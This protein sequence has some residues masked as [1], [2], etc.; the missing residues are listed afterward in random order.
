M[1]LLCRTI[2]C[3]QSTLTV[4]DAV[5]TFAKMPPKFVQRLAFPRAILYSV[6]FYTEQ[7]AALSRVNSVIFDV[8]LRNSS[9]SLTV[10]VNTMTFRCRTLCQL[11]TR[12]ELCTGDS[13]KRKGSCMRYSN[14]SR[15]SSTNSIAKSEFKT[16]P[17]V[18]EFCLPRI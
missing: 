1:P 18:V 13:D 11:K 9:V 16:F 12:C 6:P 4:C 8:A 10:S 5:N 14:S 3:C 7:I 2:N 17:L 15:S